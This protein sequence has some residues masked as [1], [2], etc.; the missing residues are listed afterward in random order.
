[1]RFPVMVAWEFMDWTRSVEYLFPGLVFS[2]II[3][4]P[5]RESLRYYSALSFAWQTCENPGSVPHC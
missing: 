5:F 1:M 3:E 2:F 4:G